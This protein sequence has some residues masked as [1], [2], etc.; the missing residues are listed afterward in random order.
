M[1][2]KFL[3]IF[4]VKDHIEKCSESTGINSVLFFLIDLLIKLH[5]EIIASLLATGA[6]ISIGRI[7]KLSWPICTAMAAFF[8]ST[9]ENSGTFMD[10]VRT[11]SLVVALLG[12]SLVFLRQRILWASGILLC[13]A[14]L[15]K[16]NA[17]IFGI[18]MSLWLWRTYNI[19]SALE[20]ASYAAVPALL[21]TFY[22]QYTSDGFFLQYLLEVPSV[23]PFVGS[24]F[25]W[26]APYEMISALSLV[27]FF[28]ILFSVFTHKVEI[29]KN[30]S[31][32]A[33]MM[34]GFFFHDELVSFFQRN[35]LFSLPSLPAQ[36]TAKSLSSI[37]MLCGGIGWLWWNK[38]LFKEY[39][40]W[41]WC[42]LMSILFCCIMRGHHGGY[43]NVLMP[44]FWFLSLILGILLQRL[45]MHKMGDYFLPS[46]ILLQLAIGGWDPS[47]YIPTEKDV[48]KGHNLIAELKEIES[49]ILAPFSPWYAYKA[50]HPASFHLIALWDI[51]HKGGVLQSY[52]KNIRK[53]ISEI[54][55]SGILVA[56]EKF[57]FGR[58][59]YYPTRKKLR[60]SQIAPKP[61]IGWRAHSKIL[62]FPVEKQ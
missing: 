43:M 53:D 57:D 22:L 56:N 3:F 1:S 54:R 20:F 5:P 58:K 35:V 12:W 32:L 24:R 31:C 47:S 4:F 62:F 29:W 48:Q 49:P 7:E 21:M 39:M 6:L 26:L 61:K 42:F 40:L 51:D 18:P 60:S 59:K 30:G 34:I 46:I 33:L 13:L 10:L 27:I 36:E 2:I 11:D 28:T 50:G 15:A 44:G 38:S 14:F 52:V 23:H 17:A 37:P 25:F 9:Y 8:L 19:R 16:H 55:W 45:Y 41:L